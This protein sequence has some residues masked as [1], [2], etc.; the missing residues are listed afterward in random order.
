MLD[1][2]NKLSYYMQS[3]YGWAL[4]VAIEIQYW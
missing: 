4:T 2:Y 3:S 1:G